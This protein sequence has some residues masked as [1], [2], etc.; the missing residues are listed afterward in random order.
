MEGMVDLGSFGDK[1][2]QKRGPIFWARSCWSARLAFAGSAATGR[3][4]SPS[5]DFST[6]KR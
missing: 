1:R 3:E 5:G 4:P 6:T 2:L